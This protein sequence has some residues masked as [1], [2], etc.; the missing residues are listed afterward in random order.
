MGFS[1]EKT[2]S[3][4]LQQ[5]TDMKHSCEGVCASYRLS[6]PLV[7]DRSGNSASSAAPFRDLRENRAEF[8][9]READLRLG[10]RKCSGRIQFERYILWVIST[11]F[12]EAQ[13][14]YRVTLSWPLLFICEWKEN[15]VRWDLMGVQREY[16][17]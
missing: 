3:R 16:R 12:N 13:A 2:Q 9:L 7:P 17:L 6:R 11:W 8:N 4:G 5:Q 1:S 15:K 10:N 14:K